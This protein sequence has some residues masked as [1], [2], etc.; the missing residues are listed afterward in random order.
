MKR[1]VWYKLIVA[2]MW[3][4]QVFGASALI[5]TILA[6]SCVRMN[7]WIGACTVLPGWLIVK[8]LNKLSK[9]GADHG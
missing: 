5:V 7:F 3:I 2:S 4:L 6:L 1:T 9:G 8:G